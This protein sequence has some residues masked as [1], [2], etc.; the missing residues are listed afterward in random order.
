[1][2]RWTPRTRAALVELERRVVGHD[3]GRLKLEWGTLDH[4]EPG[5][6]HD[7]LAWDGDRL[8]GF[9]G[10][11]AFG[12]PVVE[13]AGMV[14]P[15]ARRTGIGSRLLSAAREL[16]AGPVL[17]VTP[18]ST[19]SGAAFAA[20]HGGELDHSE[21]AMRLDSPPARGGATGWELVPA[22][23]GDQ[24]AIR[25]LLTE[26]FGHPPSSSDTSDTLVVR[27]EGRVVGMLRTELTDGVGGV[28]GF[29]ITRDRRGAGL[30]R[31]VLRQACR[32]L[33]DRGARQVGLEVAVDNDRA[34]G[35]YTS[36]GFEVIATED[37]VAL[38]SWA[39]TSSAVARTCSW[40]ASPL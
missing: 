25:A 15:S 17:L 35:V 12:A 29:M 18:R 14:D 19:P 8:V 20:A 36:V 7:L 26:G 23:G 1:M 6:G 5:R 21:F 27:V 3:G 10:L 38:P 24:D 16:A 9:A 2:D 39:S 30:G 37:Y 22:G 4:R 28:F 32:T 40:N 13:I 31:A 34:L 11:Y 33:F